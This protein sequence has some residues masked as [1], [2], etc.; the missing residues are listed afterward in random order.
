MALHSAPHQ[1]SSAL[2]GGRQGDEAELVNKI[3]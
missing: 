1:I 3:V 2:Q